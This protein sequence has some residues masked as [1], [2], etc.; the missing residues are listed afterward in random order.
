MVT[1]TEVDVWNKKEALAKNQ[2]V[3]CI[4]DEIKIKIFIARIMWSCLA[5]Y[6]HGKIRREKWRK[7]Q[8]LHNMKFN[9]C[10]NMSSFLDAL[11]MKCNELKCMDSVVDDDDV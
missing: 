8:E 1:D 5:N 9:D 4:D 3:K 11:M 6:L 10:K 7:K 2:I